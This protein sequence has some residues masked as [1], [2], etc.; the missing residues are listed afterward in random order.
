[1]GQNQLLPDTDPE[2]LICAVSGLPILRRPEWTWTCSESRFTESV[3]LIGA[4]IILSRPCGFA[5]V[6]AVENGSRMT[7]E[8][9]DAA[10]P[11]GQPFIWVEDYTGLQGSSRAARRLFTANVKSW[12]RL[13]SLVFYGLS[14]AFKVGV[15]LAKRFKA[16]DFEVTIVD[17]Y[18]EAISH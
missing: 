7:T 15:K 10:I 11:D 8:I 2:G 14:S 13:H 17:S 6:E 3:V 9:V 5:N 12:E 16:V 1:M 18:A 4:N